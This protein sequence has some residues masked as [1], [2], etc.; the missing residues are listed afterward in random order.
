MHGGGRIGAPFGWMK[1]EWM[2]KT[3]KWKEELN[4]LL[5]IARGMVDG[6][7]WARVG[8]PRLH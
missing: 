2:G 3:L 8:N 6:M 4:N 7:E 5:E 1:G